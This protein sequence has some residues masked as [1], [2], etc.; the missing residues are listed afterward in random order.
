M[1]TGS[2]LL[3]VLV[4]G[5][6]ATAIGCSDQTATDE[7]ALRN[8]A[9]VRKAHADLAA[10]DIEAFKAAISPDYKRHCQ[11]M[12]HQLQ[13]LQG[14]KESFAFIDE[15]VVA[16]PAHEDSITNMIASGDLV[17]YLSTITGTQTGTMGDFPAAEPPAGSA[18]GRSRS[19]A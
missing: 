10:R 17:A 13:E 19:R 14:T 6:L 3:A 8:M 11:A 9:V 18:G 5:L 12:P 1:K 7:I 15:F 2:H 16:V 4:P